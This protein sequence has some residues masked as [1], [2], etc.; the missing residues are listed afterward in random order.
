MNKGAVIKFM[1]VV[2]GIFLTHSVFW[3]FKVGQAEKQISKFASD[4]AGNVL[5]GEVVVSGFPFSQ[6][7]SIKDLKFTIPAQI[8]NKQQIIIKNLE[9]S[10]GI[11]SSDFTASLIDQV[12]VQDQ[13]GNIGNVEFGK[14]PE[15]KIS[16][17]DGRILNMNYQDF[18]Y[19][20]LD[21]EKNSLYAASSTSVTINSTAEGE[22]ITTKITANVKDIEGFDVVDIYKGSIEKNIIEGIKT[23]E[24]TI[25]NSNIVAAAAQ[26]N[27]QLSQPNLVAQNSLSTT[28]PSQVVSPISTSETVIVG[29][30]N[31]SDV[32]SENVVVSNT[33]PSVVDN[34]IVKSNLTLDVEYSIIPNQNQQQ[35]TV[36]FDPAQVQEMP[37]QYSKMIKVANLEFSNPLYKII[38]NGEM[39]SLPDDNL[40]SGGLTVK[41]EKIDNLIS[42]IIAGLNQVADKAKMVPVVIAQSSDL[43]S[44]GISL[45]DSYQNFLKRV[46]DNLPMVLKELAA[47][48]PVSKEDVAQFDIR[49]EKNLDFL[50]N[51]SPIREIIG[52]F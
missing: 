45:N 25:G 27:N 43:S 49:R 18:G 28:S 47:K 14:Q 42:Q 9:V 26:V 37:L 11:F 31:N 12:S 29:S 16:I 8:L 44:S 2:V 7:I 46:S 48:N 20:I 36:P 17:F 22:K 40:P 4:N 13:E 5:V 15:V 21:A 10:A 19:R 30:A 50:M 3:F 1:I 32:T 24:L 33:A 35:A 6:K 51:E 23:G 41:I 52:K 39:N 34:N 38:I